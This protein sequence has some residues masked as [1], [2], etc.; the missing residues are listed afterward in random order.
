MLVIHP[1]ECIDC[2]VCE[3]EC[4]EE[5]ILPGTDPRADAWKALNAE[6]AR[7]WR[8]IVKRGMAPDDA[9][10][11]H[12]VPDKFSRFFDPSPGTAA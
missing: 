4:P 2:G 8:N 5:A 12:S 6:Y 11:F 9:E 1:D 3:A 10:A 7:R